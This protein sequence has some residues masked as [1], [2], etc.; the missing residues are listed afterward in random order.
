MERDKYIAAM[1]W[2]APV[3]SYPTS[4]AVSRRPQPPPKPRYDE[5]QR[6][7]NAPTARASDAVLQVGD[8]LT[9][10]V[11]I[12]AHIEDE[13]DEIALANAITMPHNI[14]EFVLAARTDIRSLTGRQ[15]VLFADDMG[16][17]EVDDTDW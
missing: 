14:G 8:A 1:S 7:S 10:N 5:W 3:R 6:W 4:P 2:G 11:L 16:D 17:D 12:S 13:M 9:D 15:P